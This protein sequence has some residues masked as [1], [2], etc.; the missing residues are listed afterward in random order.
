[1]GRIWWVA[2][3]AP[4][5]EI[6]CRLRS[7]R[8]RRM[9]TSAPTGPGGTEYRFPS[10]ETRAVAAT[11]RV[12][13]VAG[14]GTGSSSSGS[15]S[16]SSPT[17]VSPRR[18]WSL[19]VTQNRSWLACASLRLVTSAV[20]HQR[21][22]KL[23]DPFV[24]DAFAVARHGTTV[25]PWCFATGTNEACSFPVVGLISVAM[26]SISPTSW[27]NTRHREGLLPGWLS[28]TTRRRE[29]EPWPMLTQEEDV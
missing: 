11:T 15:V 8:R 27:S 3:I 9:V 4:G 7:P 23:L 29:E 1:V 13:D 6:A 10:T 19:V 2:T 17:V 5:A 14:C 25:T 18:R 22:V 21:W 28:A 26:R 16:A 24:D 20:R 12:S